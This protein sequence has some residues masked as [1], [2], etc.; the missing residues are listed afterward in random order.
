LIDPHL[1]IAA[2]IGTAAY[3]VPQ[4]IRLR[5]FREGHEH[6]FREGYEKGVREG[7]QAA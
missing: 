5:G 6:G 3:A 4:Y 2:S 1:I 7:R